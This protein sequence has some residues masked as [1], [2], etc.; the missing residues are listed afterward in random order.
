VAARSRPHASAIRPIPAD[1]PD[2][3]GPEGVRLYERA[4][5]QRDDAERRRREITSRIERIAEMYKWGDITRAAYRA[6]REQL[7]GEL[8]R[9]RTTTSQAELLAQAAS[10]L[11]DLPTAWDAATPEQRN[12]LPRLDFES[13]EIEDDR[14]AAVV[15]QPDFTPFFMKRAMD[16]GLIVADNNNGASDVTPSSEVMNGRKRRGVG[17]ASSITI[18]SAR[19]PV[20]DLGTGSARDV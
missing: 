15:P 8:A 11:R 20:P 4:N 1:V 12:A 5:D 19:I 3:R 2:E 18:G 14:V 16:E 6:E 7:E 10:F 13:I 9:L 17:S